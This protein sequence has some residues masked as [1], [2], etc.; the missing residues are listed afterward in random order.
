MS[1]KYEPIREISEEAYQLALL[2]AEDKLECGR[3][4]FSDGAYAGLSEG[5]LRPLAECGY[6]AH[7]KYIDIQMVVKGHEIIGIEDLET[8]RQGECVFTF[9]ESK[10]AELWGHNDN[11]T[12]NHLYDGD[13]LIILPEHAHM[14]GA[15]PEGGDP[16][17]KKLII[18]AP[19]TLLK[20]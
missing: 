11:G 4:E 12:L 6:E 14:P 18:K 16:K 8:M 15:L 3:Y 7:R 1:N 10:D 19:V 2:A 17:V 9:D 13:Y 5:N 20:K